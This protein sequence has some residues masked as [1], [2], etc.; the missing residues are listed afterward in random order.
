MI[1]MMINLVCSE[2]THII[3]ASSQSCLINFK[4]R[5]KK[6]NKKIR[7]AIIMRKGKKS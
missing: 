3:Q 7:K 2:D 6:K 1:N 5:K 4:E